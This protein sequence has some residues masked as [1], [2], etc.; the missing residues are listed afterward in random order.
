MRFPYKALKIQIAVKMWV[1][2]HNRPVEVFGLAAA[3]RKRFI[4]AENGKGGS[5]KYT[6]RVHDASRPQE[7]ALVFSCPSAIFW[8]KAPFF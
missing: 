3:A 4:G 1:S 5:K 6:K 2:K 8:E 7:L